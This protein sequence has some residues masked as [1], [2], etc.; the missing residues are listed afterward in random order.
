[1]AT[2]SVWESNSSS[3]AVA[4]IFRFVVLSVPSNAGTFANS[5]GNMSWCIKEVRR[6]VFPDSASPIQTVF[7]L[8]LAMQLIAAEDI[9]DWDPSGIQ[10]LW[11][12]MCNGSNSAV[13]QSSWIFR[14]T[15]TTFYDNTSTVMVKWYLKQHRSF[16]C[17][18]LI[19]SKLRITLSLFFFLPFHQPLIHRVQVVVALWCWTFVYFLGRPYLYIVCKFLLKYT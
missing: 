11:M 18:T 7:T 8:L 4:R 2:T 13:H 12:W 5:W 10:L 6:D 15:K 19:H 17:L 1:M 16:K 9:A 14:I 3:P